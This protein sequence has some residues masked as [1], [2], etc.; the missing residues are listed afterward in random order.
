MVLFE[1]DQSGIMKAYIP[2]SDHEELIPEVIESL[3]A[4]GLEVLCESSP[5]WFPDDRY[6]KYGAIA[7]N[8]ERIIKKAFKAGD[9]FMVM[10]DRTRLHLKDNNIELMQQFLEKNTDWGGVAL[11]PGKKGR[12]IPFR[13]FPHISQACVMLRL[14]VLPFIKYEL[15]GRECDCKP[16][17]RSIR[18]LGKRYGYME[19]EG[20]RLKQIGGYII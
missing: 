4:Q 6:K 17:G 7:R 12:H 2:K 14:E 18:Q 8:R 15:Q 13:E 1:D 9:P 16:L 11:N 10:N 5:E 20:G 3:D 19:R